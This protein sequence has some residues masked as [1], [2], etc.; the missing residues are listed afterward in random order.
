MA[1]RQNSQRGNLMKPLLKEIRHNP[2]LW[3]LVFVPAVFAAQS[4]QARGAHAAVRAL[5]PGHRAPGGAAQPRHRVGGGQDRRCGRRIAQRHAGQPDRTGHRADRVARRAIHAG[6]GVHRRR[7]RHQHPVHAGRVV[8]P[9]RPQTSRAGIQPRQRPAASG[10]ALP[11]H[12]CAAGTL[13][14]CQ[15]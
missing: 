9:G 1:F 8:P 14:G 12:H 11:G 2:L 3:L 10:P 7:D 13:G 6:E 4:L 15:G 5:G